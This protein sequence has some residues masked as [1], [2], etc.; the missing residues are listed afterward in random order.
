VSDAASATAPAA[1]TAHAELEA[2]EPSLPAQVGVIARRSIMRVLRQ[3][4]YI[5]PPILFPLIL[6]TINASGLARAIEIPGFPHVDSYLQFSI[7]GAFM[8][9]AMFSTTIVGLAIGRDIQDGFLDRLALT[10]MRGSALLLGQ[11]AGG[12]VLGA[13]ASLVYV[14]YALLRGVPF[15]SG[16]LGVIALI[17]LGSLT[18][19]AFSGVGA[20]L[21]LRAG[22]AEAIQ[23]L[24]PLL[25]ALQFLSTVNMPLK[26]IQA[27][28]FRAIASVN[29]VSYMVDGMRS[30]IITGWSARALGLDL[31]IL[32]VVI[33]LALTIGD[34]ELRKRL[35]RA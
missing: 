21:A 34:R 30:L 8:Q 13:L 26:L 28:W 27:D 16:V 19:L 18:A 31:V 3:P 32:A 14:S 7:V 15:E 23:G 2:R 29:P 11:L 22:S 10:P 25:F 35:G 9:G 1:R 6:I 24:F 4:A 33:T 5:G 12:A 17:G 20:M